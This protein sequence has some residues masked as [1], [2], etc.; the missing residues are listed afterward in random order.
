MHWSL[1]VVVVVSASVLASLPGV[2]SAQTPPAPTPATAKP[3]T[4]K[5]AA[6]PSTPT[7]AATS[8]TETRRPVERLSD[9]AELA[10]VV[11]LY[12]AAKYQDCS[13]E[14]ERLLDPLGKTPLRQP[15][16]VENA[17]VYWAAC[18]L[19]AG[20]PELADAPLRAAIHENPQMKPPDALVFPQPVVQRFLKVRDSLVS[21]IRAAEEARIKQARQEALQREQVLERDRLRMLALERLA[22]QELVVVRNRRVLSFVPFGVGQLQ[23]RQ[24][25]LGYTLMASEALLAS[26]SIAAVAVQSRI[27]VEADDLRRQGKVVD[28]NDTLAAWGTV[29]T[30]SFWAFAALAVGGVLQAQLEYVPEFRETRSRPLPPSLRPGPRPESAARDVSY[31]PYFDGQSGGLNVVGR[32]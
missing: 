6:A 14:I 26:L 4:V 18:L 30:A 11:S 5:P 16:I 8:A 20:Q 25:T 22:Q 31:L 19:G 13:N 32:F 24:E 3:A 27:A 17:R 9:E 1:Q 28:V 2:A 23:N 7:K 15:T 21:E 29:R 12:E 10:R